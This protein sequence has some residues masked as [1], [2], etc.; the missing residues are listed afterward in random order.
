MTDEDIRKSEDRL[1]ELRDTETEANRLRDAIQ[2]S[3]TA[4]RTGPRDKRT[5][6]QIDDHLLALDQLERGFPESEGT[7]EL[8]GRSASSRPLVRLGMRRLRQEIEH[9]EKTLREETQRRAV[10]WPRP[11]RLL[12]GKRHSVDGRELA[13]GDELLLNERQAH[14]FRDRFVPVEP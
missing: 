8:L 13:A 11:Y 5:P 4:L 12:P 2:D 14:A 10:T 1:A 9:L 6:A 3:L 7:I